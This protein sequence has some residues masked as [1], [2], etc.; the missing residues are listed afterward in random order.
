[1]RVV[2][3]ERFHSRQT[4]DED[5]RLTDG[6]RVQL[7]FGPL[8]AEFGEIVVEDARRFFVD[9]SSGRQ[10]FKQRP[11]HADRLSTLPGEKECNLAHRWNPMPTFSGGSPRR[12][13]LRNTAHTRAPR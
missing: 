12:A 2:G 9:L 11:A 6:C 1:M 8:E 7:R 5:G 10:S 13:V 3:A 4:R